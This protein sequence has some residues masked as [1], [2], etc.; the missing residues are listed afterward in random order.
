MI[1]N[2]LIKIYD[3]DMMSWSQSEQVVKLKRKIKKS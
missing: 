3:N 1:K 2:N